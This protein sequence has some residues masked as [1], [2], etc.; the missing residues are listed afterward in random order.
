MCVYVCARTYVYACVHVCRVCV[1]A[2]PSVYLYLNDNLDTY[3]T[4]IN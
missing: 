2:Y 1:C 3:N 4:M